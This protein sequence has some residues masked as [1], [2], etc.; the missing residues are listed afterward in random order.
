MKVQT[1]A[2]AIPHTAVAFS[3]KKQTPFDRGAGVLLP[4]ASLPSRFGI[5][6]F[7][8]EA[9]RFIDF[10]QSAGQSYWQV[11]PLGPT[12]YGDSPYQSFS[13]FAGNPYF[14][15]LETLIAEGLLTWEEVSAPDWGCNP[16]DVDYAKIYANRF[17]VLHKAFVR[18]HHQDT[19][20]YHSFCETNHDWLEDYSLYMAVKMHF[21]ARE[22]LSWPEDI[23]TCQP[24]SVQNYRS[25]LKNEIDFWKFCQYKFYEQW[26]KLKAYAN[27]HNIRI[28]GDIPIYVSLDSAD[29][30]LHPSLFQLDA[31]RRPTAVSGVPPDA[32]STTGQLWG[33]PLYNWKGMKQDDFAWWKKRMTASAKLYDIVRIDH[34]IG[35]VRYYA[36]PYGEL[37][38]EKGEWRRGPGAELITAISS[39]MGDSKI[40]AEDLGCVVP[41]VEKLREDAGYPGMKVL[42]FAFDSGSG[43]PNLPCHYDKNCVV[44]GGTHD[45]ETMVGFFAHQPRQNIHFACDYLHTHKKKHLP[46][47][48]IR[49]AYESTADTAVLQ[50]QDW[51]G[52][53]NEARTNF[54]STI[55]TNWR[56]RLL[57]GQLTQALSTA[58]HDLCELYAR[59]P[60]EKKPDKKIDTNSSA[61][62]AEKEEPSL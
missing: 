7:G 54:P 16:A 6:T 43:N 30:W 41:E 4:V 8:Q 51:L 46:A 62:K 39:V 23:R 36:I 31:L 35:I 5:G 44:Y 13:A 53:G 34:F 25:R 29:V 24:Q 49:A 61:P 1:K 32:F 19:A 55:G 50:I 20:A 57:P 48:C 17:T 40:I 2:A 45:N 10:L 59:L 27:A 47:A 58:M 3:G 18:S 28:I 56:W 33:N 14:I 42:E 22:W 11:L 38:A 15:D 37:T 26:T 60:Q 52:L 9:Y 12:S 21:N